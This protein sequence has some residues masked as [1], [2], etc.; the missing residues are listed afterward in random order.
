[1]AQEF[2]EASEHLSESDWYV[3]DKSVHID[4]LRADSRADSRLRMG[5]EDASGLAASTRSKGLPS[6]A[7]NPKSLIGDTFLDQSFSKMNLGGESQH[8]QNLPRGALGSYISDNP[9]MYSSYLS[10]NQM[11]DTL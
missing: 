10:N 7:N 5:S 3:D 9:N 8:Y 4:Q 2:V 6:P 1:M 11:E